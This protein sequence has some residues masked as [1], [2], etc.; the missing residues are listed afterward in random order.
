MQFVLRLSAL[1]LSV[2]SRITVKLRRVETKLIDDRNALWFDTYVV[3]YAS[4]SSY[5]LN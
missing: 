3:C 5:L 2:Q 1:P 4:Q